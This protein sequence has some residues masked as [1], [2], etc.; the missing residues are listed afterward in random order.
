MHWSRRCRKPVKV[1]ESLRLI[2]SAMTCPVA[3]SSAATMET[4]PLRTYSNSRRASRPG[5]AGCSGY[6]RYLAWILVFSSMQITTVP[7]GGRRYTLHTAAAW[8]QN[9]SSPRRFSHPRTRC[10][11]SS[12]PARIR[13]AWLA[14]IP[15]PAS[16]SAID[17]CVDAV[18][19]SGGAEVAVATIASR[20]SGPYTSGRP[21]RGRSA[22]AGSPP[23]A[24]RR[25][26]VRTV[27]AE[28]PS[29]A[30]I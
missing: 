30:A 1:T 23:R 5:R 25:R 24:N 4:V 16:S 26:Q 28:Q 6:L 7:G 18:V 12:S 13:P 17:A 15:V 3:T 22:R 8:A 20:T 2:G 21:L 11:T 29:S 27:P 9:C 19:P 14:E 10:G